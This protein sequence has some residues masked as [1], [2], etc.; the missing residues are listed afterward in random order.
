MKKNTKS[1]EITRLID[2]KE[3]FDTKVKIDKIS[4]LDSQLERFK[5]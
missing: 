5:T 3:N 2:E 4:N 1:K